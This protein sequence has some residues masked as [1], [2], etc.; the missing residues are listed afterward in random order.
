MADVPAVLL[1]LFSIGLLLLVLACVVVVI[2]ILAMRFAGRADGWA[3]LARRHPAADPP[4]GQE[5]DLQT[6]RV[7]KVRYRRSVR[8]IVAPQGLW[9]SMQLKWARFVPLWVPWSDVH[10]V[11]QTSLYG[12]SAVQLSIGDPPA[13]S[14]VVYAGLFEAISPHLATG[15]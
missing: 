12:R 14:I 1:I 7:G 3:E 10:G 9:L 8:V 2:V 5:Y 4:P 11:H 6:V 15:S 13:P